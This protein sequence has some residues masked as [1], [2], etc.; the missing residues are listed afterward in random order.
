MKQYPQEIKKAVGT[1]PEVSQ[2]YSGVASAVNTLFGEVII[3]A[4][5]AEVLE[6]A[7]TR[8]SAVTLYID[9]GKFNQV[10]VLSASKFVEA[11]PDAPKTKS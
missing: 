9:P 4:Q 1:V 5:S 10:V 11:T 8:M 3:I 6:R 7:M 2:G